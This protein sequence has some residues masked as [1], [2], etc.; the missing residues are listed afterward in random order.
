MGIGEIVGVS[1]LLEAS[2]RVRFDYESGD[3]VRADTEPQSASCRE[4][5]ISRV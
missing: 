4:A 5:C 2:R 1:V 3:G